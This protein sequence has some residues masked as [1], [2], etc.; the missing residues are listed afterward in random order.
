MTARDPI[1]NIIT[2]DIETVANPR[3]SLFFQ[4]KRYKAPAN[5]KDKDKIEAHILEQRHEDMQKAAL[6][7]WTG[8][9]VCITMRP[10]RGHW[11]RKTVFGGDEAALLRQVFDIL[12]AE[13]DKPHLLGKNGDTFDRPYTIGR[14]LALNL[15][16][17]DLFRP[18]RPIE[19]INHIF[20][21]SARCDQVGKLD[22][23][24]FGLGIQGKT[25]HGTDVQGWFN[26][27]ELG[28]ES[29]WKKIAHYCADDDDIVHEMLRR[30]L[31]PYL[32]AATSLGAPS[33]PTSEPTAPEHDPPELTEDDI[34]FG[35]SSSPAMVAKAEPY[36]YDEV[37][38]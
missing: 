13:K 30:W 8:Q 38:D 10:L 25:G 7:W 28:D 37:F 11:N 1:P 21:F 27:A 24:A 4:N 12:S 9:I 2:W 14:A 5:W 32:T 17:P 35:S 20:G 23:Y 33:A 15:G 3:A 16:I 19:D 34:P 26:Q 18:Y 36:P 22:D 29:A 31:K 6:R